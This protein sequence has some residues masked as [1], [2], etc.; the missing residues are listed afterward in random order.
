LYD[1][2]DDFSLIKTNKHTIEAVIDRLSTFKKELKD[3]A[4]RKVF[5]SRLSQSI[6]EALRLADGLASVSFISDSSLE[7]PANPKEFTDRL[8]SEKF[9]CSECGISLP[10]IEPRLFHLTRRTA[11]VKSVVAW[12]HC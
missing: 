5:R 11:R 6:E 4:A 12:G 9:A 7:F 3:V 1:L 8:F 10:E 2:N